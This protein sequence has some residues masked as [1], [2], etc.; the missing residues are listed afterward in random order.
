MCVHVYLLAVQLSL[1][2]KSSQQVVWYDLNSEE[3]PSV[4]TFN[5]IIQVQDK[6]KSLQG[7]KEWGLHTVTFPENNLILF[8]ILQFETL[9]QKIK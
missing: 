1:C 6:K 3:G 2:L 7:R 4:H 8:Q 5:Q 9:P